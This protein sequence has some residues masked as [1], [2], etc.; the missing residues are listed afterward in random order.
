MFKEI[1]LEIHISKSPQC[2]IFP[3]N[4]TMLKVFITKIQSHENTYMY[5]GHPIRQYFGTRQLGFYALFLYQRH[6]EA[7]HEQ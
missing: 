4:I 1:P 7:L 2:V 6:I 5:R 3:S